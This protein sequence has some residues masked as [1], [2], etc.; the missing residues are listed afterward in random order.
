MFN[1]NIEIIKPEELET[2]VFYA[3]DTKWHV[4]IRECENGFEYVFYDEDFK[5]W[6]NGVYDDDEIQVEDA[7]EE[8]LS[9]EGLSL[10][11]CEQIDFADFLLKYNYNKKINFCRML[12]NLVKSTQKEDVPFDIL[13]VSQTTHISLNDLNFSD[14]ETYVRKHVSEILRRVGKSDKVN[15]LLVKSY[16]NN[17]NLN[18]FTNDPDMDV[19]LLYDGE[20]EEKDFEKLLK[21]NTFELDCFTIGIIPVK[22]EGW[23]FK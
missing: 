8:I 4:C 14:I 7:I 22:N 3:R 10:D 11:K 13:S 17:I 20:L 16:E 6:E 1:G 18:A 15:I 23:F 9:A 2:I 19:F 12:N 5:E 21:A